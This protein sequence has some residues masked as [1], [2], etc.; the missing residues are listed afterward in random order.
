MRVSELFESGKSKDIVHGDVVKLV[1]K[2]ALALLKAPK[3]V[4]DDVAFNMQHTDQ[5]WDESIDEVTS[6]LKNYIKTS[7][8]VKRYHAQLEHDLFLAYDTAVG[9]VI[10]NIVD[11]YNNPMNHPPGYK[12]ANLKHVDDIELPEKTIIKYLES[13]PA[14]SEAFRKNL[15]LKIKDKRDNAAARKTQL[16]DLFTPDNLTKLA[17]DV[18][19]LWEKNF[20]EATLKKIARDPRAFEL[21]DGSKPASEKELIQLILDQNFIPSA[22]DAGELVYWVMIGS[23]KLMGS[24]EDVVKNK[25]AMDFVASKSTKLSALMKKGII[26]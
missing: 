11:F 10:N 2:N 26:K 16:A 13:F 9:A 17:S 7:S 12:S 19:K 23:G 6:N 14:F 22:S 25:K 20:D 1:Y 3:A 18:D 8:E 24:L 4:L 15:E 21:P 5:F